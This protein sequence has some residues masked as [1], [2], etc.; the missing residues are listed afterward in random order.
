MGDKHPYTTA[1]VITTLGLLLCV[2][3]HV[4]A[5]KHE[6][7]RPD[8]NE[9]FMQSVRKLENRRDNCEESLLRVN[10]VRKEYEEMEACCFRE[11]DGHE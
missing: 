5:V 1:F 2:W 10:V 7:F 8:V 4:S 3:A 6:R 9:A 11:L